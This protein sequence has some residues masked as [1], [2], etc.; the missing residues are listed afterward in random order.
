MWRKTKFYVNR[1]L[2]L[3]RIVCEIVVVGPNNDASAIL[4]F[5][6]IV[7]MVKF[8]VIDL[9]KQYFNWVH[10]SEVNYML[11]FGR[12]LLWRLGSGDRD[13]VRWSKK[14]INLCQPLCHSWHF[15]HGSQKESETCD[16][17][18]LRHL[19]TCFRGIYQWPN[20]SKRPLFGQRPR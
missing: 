13:C 5:T 19:S 1:F 6:P 17:M 4:K 15:W 14:C 18:F 9:I 10:S 16:T 2:Q 3:H 8:A 11:T 20:H 12:L 7:K